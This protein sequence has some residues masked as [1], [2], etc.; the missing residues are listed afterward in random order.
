MGHRLGRL[1][2][3]QLCIHLVVTPTLQ[4]VLQAC[5]GHFRLSEDLHVDG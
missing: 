2:N 4:S 3:T 5:Q 1:S